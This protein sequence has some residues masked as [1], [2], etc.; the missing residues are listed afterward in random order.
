[1]YRKFC[2]CRIKETKAGAANWRKNEMK[3]SPGA[4]L[5]EVW[6][7]EHLSTETGSSLILYQINHWFTFD[8]VFGVRGQTQLPSTTPSVCHR[9]A[10]LKYYYNWLF[11]VSGWQYVKFSGEWMLISCWKKAL[12]MYSSSD[13]ICS[14]SCCFRKA[15]NLYLY[16]L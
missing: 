12:L 4:I 1:M 15:L 14:K 16:F 13:I 11:G 3:S 6:L 9:R 2:S 8:F 5:T 10:P 7:N